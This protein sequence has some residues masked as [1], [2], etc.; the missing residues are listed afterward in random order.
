[1]KV[2]DEAVL[3]SGRWTCALRAML[4]DTKQLMNIEQ[5]R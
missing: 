1:M 3:E 4:R 2:I 5:P